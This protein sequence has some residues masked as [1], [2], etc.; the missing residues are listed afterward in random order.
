MNA[1]SRII[2]SLTTHGVIELH[3]RPWRSGVDLLISFSCFLFAFKM[4]SKTPNRTIVVL[5]TPSKSSKAQGWIVVESANLQKIKYPPLQIVLNELEAPMCKSSVGTAFAAFSSWWR[6]QKRPS[7]STY[8]C[9]SNCNSSTT[10][11]HLASSP[12]YPT[13][14]GHRR[15]HTPPF[16]TSSSIISLYTSNDTVKY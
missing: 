15:T 14:T 2:K 12:T 13:S 11:T 7:W 8:S 16:E 10:R 6:T 9:G 1:W 5:T 4:K 3:W